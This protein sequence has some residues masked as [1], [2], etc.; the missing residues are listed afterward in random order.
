MYVASYDIILFTDALRTDLPSNSECCS[1]YPLIFC[2]D[3]ISNNLEQGMVF[4]VVIIRVL[5]DRLHITT[6]RTGATTSFSLPRVSRRKGS[7]VPNVSL[8][9]ASD[10]SGTLAGSANDGV[11][12]NLETIVHA[13]GRNY[14]QDSVKVETGSGH[15]DHGKGDSLA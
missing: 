5:N 4:S 10:G 15:F 12:I 7:A 11:Q 1:S 6:D 2:P 14:D 8:S 13:D 3:L 9:A